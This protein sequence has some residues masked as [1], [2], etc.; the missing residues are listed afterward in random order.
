LHILNERHVSVPVVIVTGLGDERVAARAL[1]EG[2][3]D[4]VIKESGY[5]GLL[6]SIAER[7]ISAFRTQRQLEEARKKL[8]ASEERYRQLVHG[9]D[10]IVWE[11][12]PETWEFT[13]VSERAEAILGYPVDR[14]LNDPDF[15]IN[16]V[17][18]DDRDEI[19]RC[20][21]EAVSERRDEVCEFRA[22]AA[23]GHTV[24]LRNLVRAFVENDKVTRMQGLMLDITERM[25][26]EMELLNAQKL[27]SVG[28][29]AGGIAHDFNNVLTAIH[30]FS[31]LVQEELGHDHPSNADIE[32]IQ[33]SVER[34]ASLTRQLLAFSRK[35]IL[36]PRILDLNAVVTGLEKMLRRIIGEDIHIVM[37]LTPKLAR[38]KA[39]PG[40]IEQVLMNLAVNARDAMPRGGELIVE[41]APACLNENCVRRHVGVEP[42]NYVM[43]A[44]T[45]T[46][47]G[48]PPAVQA[49]LFEPFFTTKEPGKGTGL[50]L[51]TVYGIVKQS[52]GDIWVYSEPDKGTTFKIYF[53]QTAAPTEQSAS[54]REPARTLTGTE[55]IL[56]VEDDEGLRQLTARMLKRCSYHVLPAA[57]AEE[58]VQ[59]CSSHNGP[60]HLLLTDVVM[61]GLG[62]R[63]L[64]CHLTKLR[65]GIRT[66][67]VSGYTNNT[68]LDR[69]E[70]SG[71]IAFLQK[72]FTRETLAKSVRAI[73]DSP[74]S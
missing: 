22:I 27:E 29:L 19:I 46:G 43:M 21:T 31:E 63:D 59:I 30:G 49:H 64:S 15:C 24:W 35:Q 47:C 51:S 60:I 67:F 45:D 9:I 37:R 26:M 53:P 5:L 1:A 54:D 73:L 40:Q 20:F 68:L 61:P 10:A 56:L 23:D 33:E 71:G 25:R 62:G 39:D 16:L 32:R 36:Q 66:L 38:I 52:G 13:F 65:P 7:A 28:L 42:G 6:P 4:Y 12:D 72:P 14:W 55:T 58:A 8:A 50:G 17:Y 11:A 69:S 57:N 3:Y 70:S 74:Q 48:M 34:A 2:A 44:V 18:P 41:T